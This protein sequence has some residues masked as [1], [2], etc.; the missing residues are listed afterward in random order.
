[1][2]YVSATLGSR[3]RHVPAWMYVQDQGDG[4]VSF[5]GASRT[6]VPVHPLR[7]GSDKTHQFILGEIIVRPHLVVAT[8]DLVGMGLAG[9]ATNDHSA[10]IEQGERIIDL[11]L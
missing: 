8:N 11:G 5:V 4:V 3:A 9:L 10:V 1:M 2:D 7:Y 6:A